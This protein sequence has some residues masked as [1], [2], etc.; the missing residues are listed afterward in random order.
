MVL[1][2]YSYEASLIKVSEYRVFT[3]PF[4]V[5]CYTPKSLL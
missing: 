3:E 4:K 5:G 2:I 1:V